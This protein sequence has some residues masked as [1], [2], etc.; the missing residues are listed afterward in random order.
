MRSACARGEGEGPR[1]AGIHQRAH[2]LPSRQP[3]TPKEEPEQDKIHPAIYAFIAY[4]GDSVLR[5]KYTGIKPFN[6][7]KIKVKTPKGLLIVL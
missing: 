2:H 5:T 4:C 3:G 1:R 6:T 7:S